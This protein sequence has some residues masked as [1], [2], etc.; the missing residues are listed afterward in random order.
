MSITDD[1]KAA[2][3]DENTKIDALLTFAIQTQAHV[4]DLQ[5][6]ND[7]LNAAGADTVALQAVIDGMKSKAAA[8]AGF[9]TPPAPVP[10]PSPEPVATPST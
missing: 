1:L 2:Q 8:I 4:L 6:Q 5:R 10:A 9:L 3:A 7:A